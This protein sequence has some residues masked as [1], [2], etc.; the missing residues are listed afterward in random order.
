MPWSSVTKRA[1]CA[2]ARVSR[3]RSVVTRQSPSAMARRITSEITRPAV[4]WLDWAKALAAASTSE[5]MS[6]VVRIGR[7]YLIRLHLMRCELMTPHRPPRPKRTIGFMSHED[8][9]GKPPRC[10]A[11]SIVKAAGKQ[12][13]T[14]PNSGKVEAKRS[15]LLPSAS[16]AGRGDGQFF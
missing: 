13:E 12:T 15:H 11:F 9:S 2:T 5:S 14:A 1:S 4:E 16:A 6:R 10:N 8:R 7:M 3:Q